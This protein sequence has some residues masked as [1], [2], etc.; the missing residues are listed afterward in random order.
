VICV[1]VVVCVS[2]RGAGEY[3][4]ELDGDFEGDEPAGGWLRGIGT[5]SEEFGDGVVADD[6]D[7]E[8]MASG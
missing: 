2:F 8:G 5:Y 3:R 7:V 1:G 4:S 6:E